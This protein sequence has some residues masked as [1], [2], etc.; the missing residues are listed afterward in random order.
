MLST[1]PSACMYGIRSP[2]SKPKL[3]M[4]PFRKYSVTRWYGCNLWRLLL[5]HSVA[6]WVWKNA[7]PISLLSARDGLLSISFLTR[8]SFSCAFYIAFCLDWCSS[9]SISCLTFTPSLLIASPLPLFT[10]DLDSSTDS[11]CGS[12]FT[13]LASTRLKSALKHVPGIK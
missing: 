9:I 2:F 5:V 3:E 1:S 4:P 10:I 7:L 12:L 6:K 8:K 11:M 13:I